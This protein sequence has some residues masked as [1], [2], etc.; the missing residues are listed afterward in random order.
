MT[1]G[2]CAK[3]DSNAPVLRFASIAQECK[4]A[5]GTLERLIGARTPQD[6]PYSLE[7]VN[8]TDGSKGESRLCLYVSATRTG[9]QHG[10]VCDSL[11]HPVGTSAG[12]LPVAARW[13]GMSLH[14]GMDDSMSSSARCSEP[15][16][17]R[18]GAE[19]LQGLLRCAS[20]PT[21]HLLLIYLI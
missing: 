6:G 7:V 18:R 5:H 16:D 4:H 13:P 15:D 17:C 8:P 12:S 1:S 21:P 9:R 10:V 2:S 19:G 20:L 11:L 3:L 14:A